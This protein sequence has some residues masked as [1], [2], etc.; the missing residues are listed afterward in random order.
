MWKYVFNKFFGYFKVCSTLASKVNHYFNL[1]NNENKHYFELSEYEINNNMK[2]I[3]EE[4]IMI[5]I[6]SKFLNNCKDENQ[7]LDKDIMIKHT[8]DK[9]KIRVIWKK[10]KFLNCT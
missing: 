4:H 7:N 9:N 6:F 1:S 3:N 10:H 8:F 5:K 2:D